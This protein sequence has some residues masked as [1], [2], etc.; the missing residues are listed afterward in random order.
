MIEGIKVFADGAELDKMVASYKAGEVSGFTTNPSLMKKAGITD[1]NE[2]AKAAVTAI[3]D[4]P[5]SFEVFADDFETMEKEARKIAT[6]GDNVFVKIPITNT[7]GESSIPLIKKLSSEGVSLNVTALLTL[8]QVQDTVDAL[9]P[10]TNNIVS[11][12]AGRVADTGVDPTELMVKSLEICKQKP[13]AELLWASTRELI[14]IIQAKDIGVDIITVP[15]AIIGKIKD[16]G[17]DLNQ[18]SLDTV[19][20]FNNDIKALG[21]S[22]L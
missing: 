10:G 2:F 1:Y 21:Y 14:N 12:F 17:K 20:G 9:T 15:P 11:V 4:M 18:V 22:I 13:G 16:I 5:L 3:P 6:F 8:E 7:K 19:I